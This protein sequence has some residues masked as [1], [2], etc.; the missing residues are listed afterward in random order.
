M[1]EEVEELKKTIAQKDE[2]I[3]GD[4]RQLNVSINRFTNNLLL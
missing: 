1:S 3:A 2:M 4:P